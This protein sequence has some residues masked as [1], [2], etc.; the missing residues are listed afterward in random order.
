MKHDFKALSS[1]GV[2]T[3]EVVFELLDGKLSVW[4]DCPAGSLGKLCKH[5]SHFLS[6][7]TEDSQNQGR[8]DDF[9]E[10]MNWIKKSQLPSV[11]DEVCLAEKELEL[12]NKKLK[13]NKK[14]LEKALR[15]GVDC[16]E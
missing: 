3:Y 14:S 4:C 10:V 6:G 11:I 8:S 1:D 9:H 12:I 2:T 13:K 5:K 7:C 16:H 15:D